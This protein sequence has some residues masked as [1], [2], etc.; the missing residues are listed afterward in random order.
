MNIIQEKLILSDYTTHHRQRSQIDP[1][2]MITTHTSMTC[3][4]CKEKGQ[5]PEH[6]QTLICGNCGL[7]MRTQG[8]SLYC[9]ME[10]E[11]E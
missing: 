9:E 5:C 3:P 7:S 4:S 2:V 1:D 10:V 11:D 8:N 6:G